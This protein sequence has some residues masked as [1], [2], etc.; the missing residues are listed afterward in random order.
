MEAR[1]CFL[2]SDRVLASLGHNITFVLFKM[3]FSPQFTRGRKC[4]RLYWI[5]SGLPGSHWSM[6]E[7]VLSDWLV[8]RHVVEGGWW[9]MMGR[10]WSPWTCA[11]SPLQLLS[12]WSSSCFWQ[13]TQEQKFQVWMRIMFSSWTFEPFLFSSPSLFIYIKQMLVGLLSFLGSDCET[14]WLWW[15]WWW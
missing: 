2:T 6:L 5:I 13:K 12:F 7:M 1:L 3:L 15:R 4:W 9:G 10:K 11:A 14:V 8:H